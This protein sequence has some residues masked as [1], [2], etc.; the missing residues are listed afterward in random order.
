VPIL[1][2]LFSIMRRVLHRRGIFSGDRGHIHHRLLDM[3]LGQH[4]V[5]IL[6]YLV[7]L[8][9]AG[10]GMFMM[11]LDAAT[12]VAI[13]IAGIVLLVVVFRSAGAVRWRETFQ[14]Y[15]R[16]RGVLRETKEMHRNFDNADLLFRDVRDV[17]QWFSAMCIAAGQMEF[18]NLS[19]ELQDSSGAKRVLAWQNPDDSH[20]SCERIKLAIPL[21]QP[22]GLEPAATHAIHACVELYVNGSVESAGRRIAFLGRLLDEHGLVSLQSSANVDI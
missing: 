19:L 11:F 16:L 1:D 9:V 10:L 17:E 8:I 3:G 12:A 15:R 7:T 21:H 22:A 4:Q 2:T 14:A 18:L 13:F 5:A 20:E 6:I